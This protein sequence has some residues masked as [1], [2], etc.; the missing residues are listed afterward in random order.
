MEGEERELK[1]TK[2]DN[3]A[4]PVEIR[5]EYVWNGYRGVHKL[6]YAGAFIDAANVIRMR[7]LCW[8]KWSVTRSLL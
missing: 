4:A 7:L 5:D 8:W 3:A 2:N 1:A 6:T